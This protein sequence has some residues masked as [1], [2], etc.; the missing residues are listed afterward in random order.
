MN[1]WTA[2]GIVMLLVALFGGAY[3]N[4]RVNVVDWA[5]GGTWWHFPVAV[6]MLIALI[7]TWAYVMA[8]GTMISIHGSE[9][10]KRVR[11]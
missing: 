5:Y 7:S 3:L 1:R 4:S 11:S 2:G 10:R 9:Y 6:V 8:E